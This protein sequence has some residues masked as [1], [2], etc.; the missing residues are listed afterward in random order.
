MPQLLP[1]TKIGI[2][3]PERFALGMA[4]GVAVAYQV[5]W[6]RYVTTVGVQN[7][8]ARGFR[9]WEYQRRA[10]LRRQP[11]LSQAIYAIAG[12]LSIFLFLL[13][14]FVNAWNP[15]W[16][17]VLGVLVAVTWIFGQRRRPPLAGV[18]A[19]N[20]EHRSGRYAADAIRLIK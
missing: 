11:R 18:E 13:I 1:N 5:R 2:G 9:I 6:N 20:N 17:I 3:G 19:I 16:A 8:S 14:S 7:S 10:L 4:I 15:A 12:S